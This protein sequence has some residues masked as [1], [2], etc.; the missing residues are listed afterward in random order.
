MVGA[1][2]ALVMRIGCGGREDGVTWE[3]AVAF[4]GCEGS[5]CCTTGRSMGGL[6]VV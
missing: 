3:F 2:S 4:C 6:A 1:G 5:S